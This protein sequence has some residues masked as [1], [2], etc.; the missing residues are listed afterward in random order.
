MKRL[1]IGISSLI[2]IMNALVLVGCDGVIDTTPTE[3][4]QPDHYYEIDGWG[5]NPDI[6]EFTPRSNPNYTCIIAIE[7]ASGFFCIPKPIKEEI[8]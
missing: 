3:L 4:Q 8:K 1:I 6:Y 7:N 5:T 2:M